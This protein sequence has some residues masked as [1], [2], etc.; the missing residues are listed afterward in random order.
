[1]A[2][3]RAVPDPQTSLYEREVVNDQLEAALEEREKLKAAAGKARKDYAEADEWA[4]GLIGELR[5]ED[6][7]ERREL[8]GRISIAE[9][10][11]AAADGGPLA[12]NFTELADAYEDLRDAH[13]AE[14][15][16]DRP[17]NPSACI[18]GRGFMLL[19]YVDFEEPA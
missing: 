7:S 15:G 14:C 4:K 10:R 18:A 6:V 12:A 16:C 3:P 1:M 2:R 13:E 9:L 11:A 5:L 8:T 19:D 17:G